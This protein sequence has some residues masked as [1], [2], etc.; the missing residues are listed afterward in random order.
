ML[1][2]SR[3]KVLTFDCYGTLIDWESGILSAVRPVTE[4][5]GI[6]ADDDTILEAYAVAEAE[7]ETG[8]YLRYEEVLRQVMAKM[9]RSL[10]MA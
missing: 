4:A 8:Y 9:C 5:C 7:V 3:F 1:D 2:F 6:D 10:R